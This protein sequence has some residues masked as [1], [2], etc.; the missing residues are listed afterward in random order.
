MG[1]KDRRERERTE[2]R[3]QILDAARQ[4]F[5]REGYE[6]V[7]MRRIADAIEYSPTAI[8]VYFKDKESLIRELCHEDFGKL[9]AEAAKMAQI[10]DP[11]ERIRALGEAYIRFGVANPNHYRL[12]FMSSFSGV[13]PTAED[14]ER[15]GDP[16]Q[17]S[18]TFLMHSIKEAMAAGRFRD[19]LNDP[20]LL[21]Q[22]FWAAAHGIA[23]LQVAKG[24]DPWIDWVSLEDRIRV[25]LD[26]ALCGLVKDYVPCDPIAAMKRKRGAK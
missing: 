22:T 15:R 4:L 17:D 1:L 6:A 18:Y 12:M 11:I 16:D 9:A 14:L 5:L 10:A 3:A 21:A 23:S 25:G 20:E 2:L 7:S 24:G 26:A 13:G 19:G 8:Y